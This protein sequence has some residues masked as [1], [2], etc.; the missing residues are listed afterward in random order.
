MR[1]EE[2]IVLGLAGLALWFILKGKQA[3]GGF[4]GAAV[5][6]TSPYATKAAPDYQG[7]QYFTDGTAI[8]PQGVYYLNGQEVWRP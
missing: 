1:S 5:V 6:S 4:G 7:W 2:L 3:G 8:S